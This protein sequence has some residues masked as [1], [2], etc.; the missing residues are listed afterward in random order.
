MAFLGGIGKALGLGTTGQVAAGLGQL[1]GG[2]VGVGQALGGVQTAFGGAQQGQAVAVD[3]PAQTLPM[4]TAQSSAREAFIGAGMLPG[5]LLSTGVQAVRPFLPAAREVLQKPAVQIGLGLGA[6]TVIDSLMDSSGRQVR[7]T[8]K[9]QMQVK[10]MVELLGIE[11]ASS[12]LG[13][14]VA[15]TAMIIT[16]KFRSRGQGITAAQLRTATR[17][18]NRI[19]HMHD[20]L[21]AAY[22][23]AARRTTTRRATG[24]RVTQIKN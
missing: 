4:E 20:K 10:Q 14:S 16:K 13:L 22:G 5:G 12:I 19:I 9:Q 2:V 7:V 3:A 23:T 24:T 6:G 8:R 18:N 17:V 15:E 21:K 11:Q 1:A